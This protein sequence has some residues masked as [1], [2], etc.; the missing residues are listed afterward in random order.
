MEFQA[1]LKCT[2]YNLFQLC[3]LVYDYLISECGHYVKKSV[4]QRNPVME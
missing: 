1:G 3:R 2:Q 4:K